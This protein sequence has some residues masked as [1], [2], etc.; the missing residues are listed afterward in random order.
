MTPV[1]HPS[2]LTTCVVLAVA[3]GGVATTIAKAKVFF[4]LREFVTA[5]SHHGGLLITC[6]Y[7]ISHWLVFAGVALY[8][9]RLVHS[10]APVVDVVVSAFASVTLATVVARLVCSLYWGPRD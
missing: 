8:Q 4:K 5:H 10:G 9:P 1:H 7:C 6:P 2:D 3:A